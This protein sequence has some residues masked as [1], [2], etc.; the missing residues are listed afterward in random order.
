MD[1]NSPW[2]YPTIFLFACSFVGT[3]LWWHARTPP[4]KRRPALSIPGQSSGQTKPVTVTPIAKSSTKGVVASSIDDQP[5]IYMW[6]ALLELLGKRPHI[7]IAGPSRQGK[8]IL[9][10]AL[11]Y[12]RSIDGHQLVILN[13]HARPNDYGGLSQVQAYG[14]INHVMKILLEELQARKEAASKGVIEFDP[15]TIVLEEAPDVMSKVHGED[16]S[17]AKPKV[18]IARRFV[19][20][21]LRQAAKYRMHLIVVTQTTLVNPL[22]IEGD[23]EALDNLLWVA[24]GDRAV[25]KMK[26]SSSLSWPAAVEWNSKWF[27]CDREPAYALSLQPINQSVVWQ[28]PSTQEQKENNSSVGTEGTSET[29]AIEGTSIEDIVAITKLLLEQKSGN[30]I[31]DTLGGKRKRRQEQIRQIKQLIEQSD[32]S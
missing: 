18:P 27:W 16:G 8:S 12:L 17:S 24:I 5:S 11:T 26:A 28:Y 32:I 1:I 20:E 4:A 6:P 14:E 21:M 2:L 13:S 29:T 7:G 30:E 23:S 22:G 3:F 9:S 10:M 25:E 15:I 19:G 31:I